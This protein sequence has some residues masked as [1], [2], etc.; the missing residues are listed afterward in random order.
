MMTPAHD[1][2]D[3]K[4]QAVEQHAWPLA[5]LGE[6]LEELAR[7][8]GLALRDTAA[9]RPAGRGSH[10]S[11]EAAEHVGTDT[12]AP[13]PWL[14]SSQV[15]SWVESAA[16]WLG[17]EAQ[18]VEIPYARIDGFLLGGG[19]ALARLPGPGAPRFLLLLRGRG[20]RVRLLGPDLAVHAAP[21][22]AVRAA[23]CAAIAGP[24]LADVER[25]LD[26]ADVPMTRRPRAR[27]GMLSERVRSVRVSDCWV[28]RTS[29]G[30]RFSHQIAQA[31]A[32]GHLAALLLAQA[33]LFAL[34]ILAWWLIGR[35]A[36]TGTVEPG[37]LAAWAL[38]LVTQV[39]LRV[40]ATWSAGM[41]A[42]GVGGA[43]KQ[44]LLAGALALAPEEIRHQ[45]AGQL[46]G[47]VIQSEV[48][49][50]L[51]M[52]GGVLILF[53]VIELSVAFWVVG[54]GAGGGGH[55][56]LLA[57]WVCL[58]AATVAHYVR[59]YDNRLGIR[60]AM[61]HDLVEQMVGYRTRLA[62]EPRERWHEGEDQL[63]DRHFDRL[64]RTDRATVVFTSVLPRGW[65]IAGVLGLVPVVLAQGVPV[66][67]MAVSIGG[68]LMAYSG[69]QRL[70]AGI[71][72]LLEVGITWK[73]IAQLFDAA[74]REERPRSFHYEYKQGGEPGAPGKPRV[75]I[76]ARDVGFRYDG[77]ARPVLAGCNLTIV[78]GARILVEGAS[79]AGKSTLGAILAG[80]RLPQ[81][82]LLLL[83][84][85]DRRTLGSKGWRRR[86]VAAPQFHENHVLLGSFAFNALMG[87]G[88]PAS[89]ADVDEATAI[90]HELD[91]GRLLER[92]PSGIHQLV[93][94]TGWQ[95]SHGERSRLYI[96]RALLQDA[97]L[98]ILDESFAALDPETLRKTLECVLR[99]AR[100]LVVIA[101]P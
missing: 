78:E 27:A 41:L 10:P 73:R 97:D 91:L 72:P 69:F 38:V 61:T 55:M 59:A 47:R 33:A 18:T 86:V 46:L 82:G 88:W 101:H 65:L 98:I 20:R 76:E 21:V 89:L 31:G 99:R 96:A 64:R 16:T 81:S 60:L 15:S 14:E 22:A 62:Q 6:A 28:L 63:V 90:C 70:A 13:A 42:I 17:I 7:H 29:P 84:G 80:L 85:L 68:V 43:L 79:G 87:R 11:D 2:P 5:Q 71:I 50:S 95:L 30:A 34:L 4:A 26:I 58:A 25:L 3:R 66:T 48:V 93:G 8:G 12:P 83:G 35:G 36:L 19:P 54:Q 100:A 51:G 32:G 37:W 56:A 77:R 44:R 49:E 40:L 94:E 57:G 75:I 23:L 24:A 92:M 39:P 9:S 45:G 67:A 1:T 52:R 74:A 53:A